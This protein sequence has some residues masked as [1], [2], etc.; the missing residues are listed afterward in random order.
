M[1]D[2]FSAGKRSWV[3]ARIKGKDTSPERLVRSILHRLGYRFRIHRSDLP[4]K[5]DIVMP[6]HRSVI[7]VH[8]CFWHLHTCK[9]ASL[10]RSNSQFWKDK[11]TANAERDEVN[12]TKLEKMGWRTLV[13]WQCE[14]KK[15][16]N[17]LVKLEEFLSHPGEDE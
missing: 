1:A 12:L 16:E 8:G 2:V 15:P 9:R 6:R 3:M 14:T 5:P 7:F 11:L 4:G 13:I 10:P 17:L